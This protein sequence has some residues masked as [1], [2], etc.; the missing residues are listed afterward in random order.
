MT[1][2]VTLHSYFKPLSTERVASGIARKGTVL[3]RIV[4][5][6][7][8]VRTITI[9]MLDASTTVTEDS[10]RAMIAAFGN[11]RKKNVR[12]VFG[13]PWSVVKR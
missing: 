10:G 6:G 11:W 8:L 7:A 12:T 2:E 13:V 9:F 4:A 1:L 3:R 5:F